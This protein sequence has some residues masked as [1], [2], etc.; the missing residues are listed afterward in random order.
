MLPSHASVT[1]IGDFM[2]RS[3]L[4][5]GGFQLGT[6]DADAECQDGKYCMFRHCW[7]G[8]EGNPCVNSSQCKSEN[9]EQQPIVCRFGGSNRNFKKC[10]EQSKKGELCFYDEDCLG[11][12][13]CYRERCWDGSEG[14]VCRDPADCQVGLVCENISLLWKECLIPTVSPKTFS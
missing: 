1:A 2:G 7:N 13:Y 8:D 6:C 4:R 12:G 3:H 5:R 11:R 14:D 10:L 9:S